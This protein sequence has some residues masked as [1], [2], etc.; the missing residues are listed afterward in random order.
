MQLHSQEE[1]NEAIHWITNK[2]GEIISV[3]P[4]KR[5]LEDIFLEEIGEKK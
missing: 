3:T 5:T 2:N 1:M 4:I